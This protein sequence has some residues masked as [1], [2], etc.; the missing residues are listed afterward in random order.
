[1]APGKCVEDAE[2]LAR[3]LRQLF[4]KKA[5]VHTVT[6]VG[7]ETPQRGEER[8]ASPWP[9]SSPAAELLL[10]L[11]GGGCSVAKKDIEWLGRQIEIEPR[12]P[13]GKPWIAADQLRDARD[14]LPV[15]P[16]RNPS[17]QGGT[18]WRLARTAEEARG[19]SG[20]TVC[21][22]TTRWSG[23]SDVGIAAVS[24]LAS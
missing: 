3:Q 8:Q 12:R 13:H 19:R 10:Y 23:A 5:Q 21:L 14:K 7:P 18:A 2:G 17:F 16:D 22:P 24:Y 1:M 15:V 6:V 9:P 20:W 4:G 11:L